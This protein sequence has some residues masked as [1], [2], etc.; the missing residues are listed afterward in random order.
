MTSYNV[1]QNIVLAGIIHHGGEISQ[2][3]LDFIVQA[4]CIHK[5]RTHILGADDMSMLA[6]MYE[7]QKEIMFPDMSCASFQVASQPEVVTNTENRID[8]IQAARD[9][10]RKDI[11]EHFDFA[12]RDEAAI[13]LADMDVSQLP[14]LDQ[15]V[16]NAAKM[17]KRFGID[18][19]VLC[20]SGKMLHPYGYYDTFATVLLPDTFVYPVAGRP[21]M[22]ARP[23]EDASLIIGANFSAEALLNWF[24]HEGGVNARPIP[25]KSCFG[26]LA[27]YRASKWLDERC[28]YKDLHPEINAKYANKFDKAPCEHVVLHNCLREIDPEVVVAVQPD[29]H[30]VWHTS[31]GPDY[32]LAAYP[33]LAVN[34]ILNHLDLVLGSRRLQVNTT[35][36]TTLNITTPIY[37]SSLVELYY[38]ALLDKEIDLSDLDFKTSSFL[39]VTGSNSTS[40]YNATTK[41]IDATNSSLSTNATHGTNCTLMTTERRMIDLANVFRELHALPCSNVTTGNFTGRNCTNSSSIHG[42]IKWIYDVEDGTRF[43]GRHNHTNRTNTTVLIDDT[44]YDNYNGS[45][46]N[47]EIHNDPEE[48]GLELGEAVVD[49]HQQLEEIME[50][51]NEPEEMIPLKPRLDFLIAGFPKC[52]TTSLLYAFKD[53]KETEVVDTELCAL[54][55]ADFS[56]GQVFDELD[57]ELSRLSRDSSVKRGIKCPVSLSTSHSLERLDAHSPDAKLLIGVRHPVEYFQSYYNYRITEIYDNNLSVDTIPPIDSLIGSSEWMGVSTDSARFDL[58]LKQL[59]KT[60][61]SLEEFEDMAGRPHLAVKPNRFRIFLYSLSQMEDET[62]ERKQS[63]TEQMQNF[64]GLVEPFPVITQRNKNHFIGDNAHKETIDI[65][66]DKFAEVRT[67]LVKQG[68]ETQRWIREEF[69]HSHDVVVANHDHF[70]EMLDT[71]S[72][73]PCRKAGTYG[74]TVGGIWSYIMS[75]VAPLYYVA[76]SFFS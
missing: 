32:A 42:F 61:M 76:R 58:Y 27:I 64:L 1:N 16:G 67:V 57:H 66:D 20:S 24:H 8:R 59:A 40:V 37:N 54:A 74:E 49:D 39:N 69:M 12:D 55:E 72:V 7:Q 19:D 6:F 29:M 13:I 50:A 35:N 52:G 65:C 14:P 5:I 34:F 43:T 47:A 18:V 25:V 60:E 44:L 48:R 21:V 45:Y 63:F 31:A 23:E 62:V 51:S 10:Q 22:A 56:E 33:D 9:F 68:A 4:T 11:A 17:N 46:Y 3:S 41:C 38:T 26:G 15:V 36:A 30:T 2:R 73:D 71:W 53:H 28:S 75:F 70:L